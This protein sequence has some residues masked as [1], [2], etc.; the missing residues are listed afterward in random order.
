MN[1]DYSGAISQFGKVTKGLLEGD[2]VIYF[3]IVL[4]LR[5]KII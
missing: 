5:F 4:K 2:I 1:K 3:I